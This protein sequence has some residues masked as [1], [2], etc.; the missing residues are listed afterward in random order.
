M[1]VRVRWNGSKYE[2][3]NL[4]VCEREREW[5]WVCV[6]SRLRPCNVHVDCFSRRFG[7]MEYCHRRE[8][9]GGCRTTEG[10]V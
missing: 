1:V 3:E 10:S 4:R 6:R 7:S 9:A 2:C 8:L 5:E